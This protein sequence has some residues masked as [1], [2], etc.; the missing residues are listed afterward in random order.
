[1]IPFIPAGSWFIQRAQSSS[2]PDEWATI[3]QLGKHKELRSGC[4]FMLL[5]VGTNH[6]V[7]K[8]SACPDVGAK[9]VV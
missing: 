1:M 3:Q 9:F 2:L 6:K 5:F 7:N 4:A 8:R